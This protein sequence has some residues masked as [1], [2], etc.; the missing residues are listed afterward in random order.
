MIKGFLLNTYKRRLE[1]E[2]NDMNIKDL[3]EYTIG[4]NIGCEL[5]DF[6]RRITEEVIRESVTI[7]GDEISDG[8]Y[9]IIFLMANGKEY[10]TVSKAWYTKEFVFDT[11]MDVLIDYFQDVWEHRKIE[12]FNSRNM[13]ICY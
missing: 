10:T 4:S 13:E 1:C 2:L 6:Y 8:K 3:E 7:I 9:E 11:V 5:A 12:V